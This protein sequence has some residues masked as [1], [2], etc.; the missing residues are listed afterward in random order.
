MVSLDNKYIYYL[1]RHVYDHS[2]YDLNQGFGLKWKKFFQDLKLFENLVSTLPSHIWLL[3]YLFLT[4][5]QA[6]AEMWHHIWNTHKMQLKG[7]RDQSPQEM[8]FFGTIIQGPQGL[9]ATE[10]PPD[11]DIEDVYNYGVDWEEYEDETLMANFLASNPGH[12]HDVFTPHH[13]R[14]FS[15][16]DVIAPNCPLTG[17]ELAYFEHLLE[18][19]V[20]RFSQSMISR[21]A[22]WK[23]AL[24]LC[25]DLLKGRE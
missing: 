5:I 15:V 3:H 11:E 13:P 4:A 8:F 22:V 16:V 17:P 9:Y 7:E 1:K 18:V 23:T 25:I 6:D 24:G 21:R 12:H 19:R 20:D 10:E 14:T 2:W